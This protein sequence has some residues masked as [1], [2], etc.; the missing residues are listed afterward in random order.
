ARIAHHPDRRRVGV[1]DISAVVSES[2][3]ARAGRRETARRI[4]YAVR[5]C[6]CREVS[7]WTR[8]HRRV[9]ARPVHEH[10]HVHEHD[11]LG[12]F[13]LVHVLVLVNGEGVMT[14][15]SN[16]TTP[17][18]RRILRNRPTR[19]K[20]HASTYPLHTGGSSAFCR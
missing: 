1:D 15:Q 13:V 20:T 6:P 16:P 12:S 10:E 14:R 4:G 19:R 11:M 18:H 3:L 9:T 8:D 7:G 5:S 17:F 2:H